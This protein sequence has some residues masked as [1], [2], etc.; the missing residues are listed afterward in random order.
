MQRKGKRYSILLS[1]VL[2]ASAYGGEEQPE[3]VP[4]TSDTEKQE[5]DTKKV[6]R[7]IGHFVKKNLD[8]MGSSVD[9][10]EVLRGLRDAFDGKEAPMDETECMRIVGTMREEA[11]AR[12]ASKNLEEAEAFL[13][14]NRAKEG[15]IEADPGRLQYRVDREGSGAVVEKDH[16][17]ML[18]Y[19]GRLPGGKLFTAS[20][21]EQS[22]P[23]GSS[24]PGFGKGVVG[25]KEGER[26]TLY[27][28]PSIGFGTDTYLAPNTLL[29]FEVEV[30][31]AHVPVREEVGSATARSSAEGP[32]A[33]ES[34]RERVSAESE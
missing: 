30:L 27:I 14:D 34:V 18:R 28:H 11:S 7:A 17:P 33:E 9:G 20:G 23:L 12:L 10:E 29:I 22:I 13:A 25:M 16:S 24:I 5:F 21:E 6:S 1:A 4:A 15:V 3:S 31:K 26:R 19:T 8:V 32:P 2:F